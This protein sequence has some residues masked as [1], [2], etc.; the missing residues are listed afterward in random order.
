MSRKLRILLIGSILF[1]TTAR[2][3]SPI[4]LA[5]TVGGKEVRGPVVKFD[6]WALEI[7]KGAR[8]RFAEDELLSLAQAGMALPEL[9]TDDQLLL[10]NGD[11][12]P[13]KEL[14]LRD[15]KL[16]FRHKDLGNDKEVSISLS[17]VSLI[18]RL[19]P[20]GVVSPEQLR[21]RLLRTTRSRDLILLRN[22]DTIEGTLHGLKDGTVEIEVNKKLASARWNQVA[23]L[24]MSSELL[25]RLRPKGRHAR[26]ILAATNGSPGGRLTLT[27]LSA[28]DQALE[29]KTVFGATL[30]VPLERIVAVEMGGE[31]IVHLK[32]LKLSKY[33]YVAYLDEKWGWSSDMNV[34]GRDLRIAGSVWERGIS[35]HA[36]S[37]LTYSLNG[38]YR[39]LDCVVGLDDRD[40]KKGR[41]KARILVDGKAIALTR[42]D[43][44]THADG[45]IRV[46]V[47]VKGAKELT[48]E[49]LAAERGP[50][51][52]VVN[53]ANA[54]LVK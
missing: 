4:F 37:R 36:T 22:G 39:R 11:R 12:I 24:A 7:G 46:N 17:A 14:H 30:R 1:V 53:W 27:A 16:F 48:L 6:G 45:A 2:A 10:A 18:W 50:V 5:R 41:V 25:D 35:M 38:E 15:E 32:D 49:V 8:R 21:N 34:H 29:G 52:G 54:R 26:I 33:E 19:S 43:I 3:D 31:N 40:G 20:D 44:L 28:D 42:S 13:V 9:P 23:A 47:D 51:Q